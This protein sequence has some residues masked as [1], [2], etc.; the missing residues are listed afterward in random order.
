MN[1]GL[2]LLPFSGGYPRLTLSVILPYDAR[3]FLTEIPFGMIPRGRPTELLTYYTMFLTE[4][5]DSFRE[6]SMNIQA[7]RSVRMTPNARDLIL[8]ALE[9]MPTSDRQH[10]AERTGLSRA[11]VSRVTE[12]LAVEGCLIASPSLIGDCRR[13]TLLYSAAPAETVL[14][15]RL[16]SDRVEVRLTDTALRHLTCASA[17]TGGA[18]TPEQSLAHL[19]RRMETGLTAARGGRLPPPPCAVIITDRLSEETARGLSQVLREELTISHT[20]TVSLVTALSLAVP[21]LDIPREACTLLCLRR[22]KTLRAAILTRDE[23]S[24]SWIPSPLTRAIRLPADCLT[25]RDPIACR[26]ELT[27]YLRDLFRFLSPDGLVLEADPDAVSFR[28]IREILPSSCLFFPVPLLPERSDLYHLGAACIGR[29][30]L[31][32][33][34]DPGDTA[35][36]DT[37]RVVAALSV[38]DRLEGNS[39]PHPCHPTAVESPS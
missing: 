24:L 17:D 19:L 37:A 1:G 21:R 28:S 16:T 36:G 23:G 25:D 35:R 7:T 15:V 6:V 33:Y 12:R 30:F 20:L 2:F 27:A 13:G 3:T 11:T 31:W 10:L 22:S 34:G 26:K 39:A 14:T 38:S 18:H 32:R 4:S 29:R 9:A 5:Q 8:E